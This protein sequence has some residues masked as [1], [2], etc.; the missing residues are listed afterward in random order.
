MEKELKYVNHYD[1][2][3]IQTILNKTPVIRSNNK[4]R[5]KRPLMNT[6]SIINKNNQ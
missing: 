5:A 1:Q 2:Q 3:K 4:E 6:L